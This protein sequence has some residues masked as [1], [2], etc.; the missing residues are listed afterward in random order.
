MNGNAAGA[1]LWEPYELDLREYL[2]AGENEIELTIVNNLRN[3][4]G[5]HHH[6]DGECIHPGP[7]S[8]RTLPSV[9][10]NMKEL[11]WN[12]DYCFVEL[13]VE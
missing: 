10:T 2:E 7:V 6:V 8:F 12:K 3:M 11:P 1:L 9:W 13:T 4:M 5:P